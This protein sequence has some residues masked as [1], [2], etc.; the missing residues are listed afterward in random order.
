M[1]LFPHTVVN[2]VDSQLFELIRAMILENSKG[3]KTQNHK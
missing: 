1:Y 3:L 2:I